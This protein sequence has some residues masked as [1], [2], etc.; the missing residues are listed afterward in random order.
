MADKITIAIKDTPATKFEALIN[1]E[2]VNY[3][4]AIKYAEEGEN[5]A[6][7]VNKPEA[8]FDRY[9][10]DKISFKLILDGTGAV[11]A[12]QPTVKDQ[13]DKLKEVVYDY[14][15]SNHEPNEVTITWGGFLEGFNC[16]LQTMTVNYKLFKTDG[17]PLRAEVDLS[18]IESTPAQ[19]DAQQRNN[20]SPDLSHLV[21]IKAG[22]TLPMLCQKIYKNPMMY[23]EVARHNGLVSFRDLKPGMEILFPPVKK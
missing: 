4:V 16:R 9:E 19:Q 17:S 20:S 5:T 3:N 22:D 15:G 12:N 13:L 6:T 11:I 2:T 23:L 10:N 8:R 14:N 7:G 18:F 21:L 1:P